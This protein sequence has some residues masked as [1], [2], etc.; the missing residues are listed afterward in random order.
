MALRGEQVLRLTAHVELAGHDLTGMSHV[1]VLEAA[2][3]AV[4]DHRVHDLPG[5]HTQALARVVQQVGAVA[6]GLHAAGNGHLDVAGG[7]A[8][9]G[10]HDGLEARPADLV[11]GEGAHRVE[12]AASKCGLPGRRLPESCRDHVAEDALFDGGRVDAGTSYRFAHREG[13]ELRGREGF[14]PTK[15]LAGRGAYGGDDDRVLHGSIVAVAYRTTTSKPATTPSPSS[16]ASR[17]LMSAAAFS[18]SR[19]QAAPCVVTR[20]I[21]PVRVTVVTLERAG[22][23]A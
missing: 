7:D 11:D 19:C 23:T 9:C 4:I 17:V 8:L 6:H 13:S 20:R 12:E 1:Q 15:E 22:P 2:P 3:Q 18:I 5:A 10:Q 21:F 14:E 16:R